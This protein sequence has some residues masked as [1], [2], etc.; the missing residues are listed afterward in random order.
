[1]SKIQIN[2]LGF[3]RIGENRELKKT[4]EAFWKGDLNE[5]QLQLEAKE[6]R[7]KHW[8]LQKDKGV[9]LIPSNDF[10]FYDQVLDMQCLLGCV[11]ERF[12]ELGESVALETYFEMARG[13]GCCSQQGQ[14][15]LEMTKW[16]D[17]NYHYLV[18]EFTEN[19][20]FK[21]SSSKVFDEFSE[22]LSLDIKTKP[23]LIG[24]V[25]FLYLGKNYGSEEFDKYSLLEKILPLYAKIINRLEDLGAEWIQFDEPI[26]S[27]DLD[28]QQKS[29]LSKAYDYL[30]LQKKSAKLLVVNYFG[31]LRDNFDC[32]TELEVDALHVDLVRG[33]ADFEHLCETDF[34]DKILSLGLVNGRNI[35]KNNYL[36]S[37]NKIK[38]VSAAMVADKLW[39]AP[40]CSLLH[41]P[42]SFKNENEIDE[43]V[44]NYLAFTIE[45][46]A[47]L[48]DLQAL[49]ISFN[50][51]ALKKNTQIWEDHG[52]DV[53]I[54]NPHLRLTCE[55]SKQP[56]YIER[57]DF[58]ERIA[59][60]REKL[61]LP[62]LPT[63]TIGSFPQ[64]GELRKQRAL[65]KK[66]KLSLSEYE[67]YLVLEIEAVV[68]QQ[69]EIGLDVL[70][71]GEAERNDMVEYFGERLNGFV[72]SSFGWVQSYGS[73]CVKPPIIFGDVSRKTAMTVKWSSYAASL[74]DKPMKGMLTGP[75]T[76]L[77]WSFV[78]EDISRSDVT[79]QI[80]LAIREETIDLEENG[81]ELIQIDEPAIREGL[82]VRASDKD[83]YLKWAV[84]AFRVSAS[85]V[86]DSTQIHTHM[87]YSDFN[88]IMGA[89]VEMD[90]DVISIEAS[91]SDMELLDVFNDVA[92][93]NE[94]GPGVYDIHSPRIPTVD[95][96]AE[97]IKRI[98]KQVLL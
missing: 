46:L 12:G 34:G 87:C 27:L 36:S 21:L 20:E 17:T 54:C 39:I 66:G 83:S 55:R 31:D 79:R 48:K 16:F 15:A 60:Q 18:P 24:P 6:L 96:M 61:N 32:F 11:P 78:R 29:L 75:V 56:D 73:R 88:E 35:W 70:V 89:V 57:L 45:K 81:I 47:E 2:N 13:R 8:Q 23:V 77:Q 10:S 52:R 82:P 19:S 86:K 72:F 58:K 65:Y 30:S 53:R 69:E 4:L 59:Q 85:G 84:N 40:S 64:T 22:A 33:E 97:L 50:G 28:E 25:T 41:S 42:Y 98:L 63:T 67:A 76:I 74:T 38:K 62:V 3:P 94:I 5:A 14:R 71:H 49:S 37:L 91:R 95:S 51:N 68:R 9:D 93:P 43:T 92:Y 80:A 26:F 1:M 44:K 7:Q 90:A